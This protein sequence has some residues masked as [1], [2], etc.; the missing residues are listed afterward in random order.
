MSDPSQPQALPTVQPS[1][2]DDGPAPASDRWA[3]RG[4]L[5]GCFDGRQSLAVAFWLFGVAMSVAITIGGAALSNA[6]GPSAFRGVLFT[7]T[8]AIIIT[9]IAAWY[10][11]VKCRRNTSSPIFTA[12][13]LIIV[14]FDI[15]FGTVKWP[16]MLFAVSMA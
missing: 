11:I 3:Q 15:V 10:A 8:L 5:R 12:L 7:T 2:Q 6:L 4:G 16:A 13:A 1:A 9:R 14:A